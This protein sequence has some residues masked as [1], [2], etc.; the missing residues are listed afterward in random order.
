M[1]DRWRVLIIDDEAD[2]REVT[3]LTLQD[4]GY[5]VETAA[6][7]IEGVGRCESFAPEIDIMLEEIQDY[8]SSI[9][10]RGISQ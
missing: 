10:T 4:A 8:N 1:T 3:A 7:G 5:V 6:D 9:Q 2:I